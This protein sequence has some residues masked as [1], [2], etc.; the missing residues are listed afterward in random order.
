MRRQLDV[1][2]ALIRPALAK[3]DSP[4]FEETAVYERVFELAGRQ[5]GKPLPRAVLPR[6]RLH[7]PKI[8]RNL[9]TAWFANR[10]HERWKRC[11]AR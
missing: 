1:N 6:I 4:D 9:T 8:T 7:S 2:E 11:M 10:V 3:G 5:A